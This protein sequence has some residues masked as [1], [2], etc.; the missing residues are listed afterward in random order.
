[1]RKLYSI[2]RAHKTRLLTTDMTKM[3]EES[4]QRDDELASRKLS[5]KKFLSLQ[6]GHDISYH[7]EL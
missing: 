7:Y 4:L 5:T 2:I 1:M 3:I 6:L